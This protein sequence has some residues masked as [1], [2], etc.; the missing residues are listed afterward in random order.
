MAL[1][2]CFSTTVENSPLRLSKVSNAIEGGICLKSR[3]VA[4]PALKVLS[5]ILR[6]IEMP[7][8]WSRH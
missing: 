8:R 7:E 4:E 1:P 2:L 3:V 6:G 5:R